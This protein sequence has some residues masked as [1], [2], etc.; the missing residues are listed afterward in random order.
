MTLYQIATLTV[1]GLAAMLPD[2]AALGQTADTVEAHIAAAKAAGGEQHPAIF[3]SLCMAPAAGSDRCRHRD[4][5]RRPRTANFHVE[6]VKV[7][8]NLYFVGEKEYSAWA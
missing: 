3:N 8:D 7:F 5:R 4:R 1:A 6:P 2:A